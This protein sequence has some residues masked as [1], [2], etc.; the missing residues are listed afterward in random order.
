MPLLNNTADNGYMGVN[1]YVDDSG[2]IKELA[3]N[4]RASELAA[5]CGTH[6]QVHGDAFIARFRDDDDNF[7]RLDFQIGELSSAAPWVQVK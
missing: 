3:I 4:R 1:L 5:C 2:A 7:E 6:V